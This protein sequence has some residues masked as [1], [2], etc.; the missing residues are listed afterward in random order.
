MARRGKKQRQH[1]KHQ[2]KKRKKK[3][4]PLTAKD[5]VAAGEWLSRAIGNIEQAI[6]LAARMSKEPSRRGDVD[7]RTAL[8]KYAENVVEAISQFDNATNRTLLKELVEIPMNGQ[9]DGLTWDGLKGMRIRL[10]HK[11]WEIDHEIVYQTVRDE[12]PVVADL[13]KCVH[14]APEIFDPRRER[15]FQ[16]RMDASVF[17]Q[18]KYPTEPNEPFLPGRFGVV[19]FY[20]KICGWALFRMGHDKDRMVRLAYFS[21]SWPAPGRFS[22]LG[23]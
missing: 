15:T 22:L 7:L 21:G 14:V 18:I 3:Q 16:Y 6:R 19:A 10:A 8:A 2:R 5:L 4:Q 20:D 11:F 17:K 1:Q 13:L 9:K 12:F 23:R